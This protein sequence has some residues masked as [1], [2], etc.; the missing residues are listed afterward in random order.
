MCLICSCAG[1]LIFL[2]NFMNLSSTRQ[3]LSSKLSIWITNFLK[4]PITL[5]WNY[6]GEFLFKYPIIKKINQVIFK[7]KNNFRLKYLYNIMGSWLIYPCHMTKEMIREGDVYH[8]VGEGPF[9]LIKFLIWLDKFN[10]FIF[11]CT[12]TALI[13]INTRLRGF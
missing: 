4:N 8:L 3:N 11:W 1:S 10:H 6:V 2:L 7:K 9:F 5:K 12:F 13:S